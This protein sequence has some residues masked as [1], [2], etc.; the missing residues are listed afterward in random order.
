MVCANPQQ[1]HT[2]IA[3]VREAAEAD[4]AARLARQVE[5]RAGGRMR[6]CVLDEDRVCVMRHPC[7]EGYCGYAHARRTI[8][9]MDS[10]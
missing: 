9:M 3:A 6:V 1:R 7:P 8:E 10:K 5:E 4:Y 2:K